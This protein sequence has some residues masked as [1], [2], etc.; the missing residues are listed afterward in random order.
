VARAGGD[1]GAARALESRIHE[2]L[3]SDAVEEGE[4]HHG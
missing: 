4:L 1:P 3:F 2:M